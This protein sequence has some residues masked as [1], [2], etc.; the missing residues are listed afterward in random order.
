VNDWKEE[1]LRGLE[2]WRRR[3]RISIRGEEVVEESKD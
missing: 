2:V 3:R 1:G